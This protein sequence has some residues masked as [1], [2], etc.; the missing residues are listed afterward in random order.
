MW[1]VIKLCTKGRKCEKFYS[2]INQV[3]NKEDIANVRAHV[4]N[5]VRDDIHGGAR[6]AK[7]HLPAYRAPGPR[8]PRG[9]IRP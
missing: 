8:V 4:A 1:E 7:A 5:I 3:N 9:W 6:R 2:Y